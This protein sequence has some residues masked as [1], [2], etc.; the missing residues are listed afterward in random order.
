M[1]DLVGGEDTPAEQPYK[2]A[3][4]SSERSKAAKAGW[5]KAREEKMLIAETV[6]SDQSF[7]H[8][9]KLISIL[10]FNCKLLIMISYKC[11]DRSVI[12]N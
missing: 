3:Y 5:A 9:S 4:T 7:Y 6:S 11:D 10:I 1:Q 8:R 2:K 12:K